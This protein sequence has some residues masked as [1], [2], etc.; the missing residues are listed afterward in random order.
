MKRTTLVCVGMLCVLSGLRGQ[1]AE[2]AERLLNQ[3]WH[4]FSV[5]GETNAVALFEQVLVANPKPPIKAKA[6]I[7]LGKCQQAFG[8]RKKAQATWERVAQE[9]PWRLNLHG[10]AHHI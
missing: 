6:L 2:E 1:A 4:K 10:R 3:A 8:Q 7:G 9:E 5:Q